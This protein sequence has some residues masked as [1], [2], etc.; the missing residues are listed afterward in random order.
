MF[1][2][3]DQN[4][5]ILHI[6]NGKRYE[7]NK[8]NF[9]S[10]WLRSVSTFSNNSI[11]D[12]PVV[13]IPVVVHVVYKSE[14]ENISD[15]RIHSQLAVLNQEFRKQNNSIDSVPDVWKHLVADSRI[16]FRL[17]IKDPEG[18]PSSGITRNP[19]DNDEFLHGEDQNGN[20]L[21]EKIKF[22]RM[23]GKDAWD[24]S[25]YFNIWVCNLDGINR[26]GSRSG[27]IGY[28][29][30]PD[31]PPLTDGVVMRYEAFGT[32]TG[33]NPPLHLGRVTV[34]ECGH[35]LGLYHIW[36]DNS[37]F[38]EQNWC[39]TGGDNIDDTPN[40]RGPNRGSPRF[41]SLDEACG[42]TGPNGTMFVNHM[43]YT[44]DQARS[45]FT[46][47]QVARMRYTLEA[48]RRPLIQNDVLR[49]PS[50]ESS[51][52]DLR[53]LPPEVYNGVDSMVKVEDMF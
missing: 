15:A 52:A 46:L 4:Q 36:G 20:P 53:R 47:G 11:L 29:Q 17:A 41:P 13:T 42:D 28:A 9:E 3:T 30:F 7:R 2:N 44:E 35:Y 48:S 24:T 12:L 32:G 37:D 39:S 27:T 31:M 22:S 19:T 43:D 25:R 8:V 16:E 6:Q 5:R 1:C 40:Q 34:H 51:L 10:G 23:G 50:E 21:P 45:M 18:N 33:V 49:S 38:E 14:K 26:D